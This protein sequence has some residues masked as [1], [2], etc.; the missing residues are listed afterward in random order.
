[1]TI[2]DA[3][4]TPRPAL[5]VA[6]REGSQPQHDAAESST[7]ITDLM[8]GRVNE[9]GYVNYLRSLRP[10]YAALEETA[11]ELAEDPLIAPLHDPALERLESLD[12]DLESWRTGDPAEE[13]CAG[14]AAEA[15]AAA[16]RATVDQPERFVAHHYTRYLG[17]LS[18]GQAIGRILDRD[19]A[20]QGAG[21]SFYRFDSI[22]KV[23]VYKDGYRER[24]D[25]LPLD[26]AQQVAAVEEV[27]HAFSH[28]QAVFA[29]LAQHLALFAR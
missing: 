12:A 18:G 9:A 25:A 14:R 2:L 26:A 23:K 21:L 5:S 22:P 6:F 10:V 19:F 11:R 1:M 8:G 28:N 3:P 17:D 29:E 16:I 20:R 15:Y 24:L 4:S 7:F 13:A 27:Q